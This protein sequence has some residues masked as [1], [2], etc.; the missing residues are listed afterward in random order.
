VRRA[1]L[2][3]PGPG[4]F[5][6]G[7]PARQ[8]AAAL[9]LLAAGCATAGYRI[10]GESLLHGYLERSRERPVLI[11]DIDDTVVE[12]GFWNAFLL[13]TRI[14]RG[15]VAPFEG[16][17]RSLEQLEGRWN[18]VILT[19]RDGCLRGP[20]LVWLSENRFPSTPVIFS[21]RAIFTA[22]G[23]AEYKRLAIGDLLKKGLQ[24]GWGIGDK[25]SDML[26]YRQNGLH[27]VL[28]LDGPRDPDLGKTLEALEVPAIGPGGIVRGPDH[29][30]LSPARAWE[31][32]P[33]LIGP[34]G[35]AGPA[36]ESAARAGSPTP[37]SSASR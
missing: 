3:P 19:A 18:V 32:I 23:R 26:A 35:S 1:A 10:E 36:A 15:G 25:A 27:T 22:A 28:I 8:A 31:E 24:P 30:L 4:L 37:V 6:P 14:C 33:N 29:V 20:T 7:R 13:W 17:P 2:A 21:R 16:A 12:G 11:V 9:L 5:R 34:A